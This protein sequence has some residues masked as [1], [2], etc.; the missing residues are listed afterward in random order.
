MGIPAR[1]RGLTALIEPDTDH[2]AG[3]RPVARVK[4]ASTWQLH[5]GFE[6]SLKTS[7]MR[8]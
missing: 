8:K 6:T 7:Q 5:V 4:A 2:L 3:P 1:R